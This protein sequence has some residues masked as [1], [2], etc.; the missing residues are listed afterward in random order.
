MKCPYRKVIYHIP[1]AYMQAPCDK[2]EFAECYGKICPHYDNGV[3][4]KVEK[5]GRL[6]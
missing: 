3:C 6:R 2:E 4:R 1:A 5:E